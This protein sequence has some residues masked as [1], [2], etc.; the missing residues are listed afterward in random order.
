VDSL[1]DL[2]R[3]LQSPYGVAQAA[4]GE[5][6]FVSVVVP[7][8]NCASDVDGFAACMRAQT[9]PADRFEVIVVDNGSTDGT[10]EGAEQVGFITVLRQERGRSK[11]LNAGLAHA[12][13]EYILTTDLSC[14]AAADWIEAVVATFQA[15][16]NAACVAGDIRLLKTAEGP[17]IRFQDRNNYMSPLLALSRNRLPFLPFADGANASFT[18]R[19]FEEIGGFEETFSKAAD[20]EICYRLLVLT[21]YDIVFNRHALMWE[22]G[23]ESLRALLRQR[24][25][26]GLGSCLLAR[27]FP[28]F[29]SG[30]NVGPRSLRALYWRWRASLTKL[31]SLVGLNFLALFGRG[32]SAA[33]DA[34][35]R[36]LMG[37]AQTLGESRGRRQL[38]RVADLPKPIDHAKVSDFVSSVDDE[39]RGRIKLVAIPAIAPTGPAG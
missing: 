21:D 1:T 4:S 10:L 34:N 22:P 8:L 25:R 6:P 11:A 38:G 23:E 36:L 16:P 17:A 14:R 33:E 18:R 9:Y 29:F 28:D 32:R 5:R 19:L 35:I 3:P 37:L 30:T 26:M 27:R 12:R 24:L 13:G 31:I 20:V 2:N 7:A 15:H 39:L